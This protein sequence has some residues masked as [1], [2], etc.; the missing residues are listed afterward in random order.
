MADL[1]LYAHLGV[2]KPVDDD[3]RSFIARKQGKTLRCKVTEPRNFAHRAKFFVMVD[4]MVDNSTYSKKQIVNL[5][6]LGIGHVDLCETPSGIERWPASISF[7]E[8]TDIEFN[9]FYNRA[10]NWVLST[11]IP[12]GRDQLDAEVTERL[13]RF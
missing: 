6:K 13:L 5:I 8:M 9:D 3:G 2:L 4:I 12:M 7:E 1:Y 11:L 10:V